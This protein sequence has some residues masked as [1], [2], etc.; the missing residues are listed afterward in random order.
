MESRKLDEPSFE[1]KLLESAPRIIDHILNKEFES[2]D[3]H[4]MTPLDALNK[5]A[6][7]KEKLKLVSPREKAAL[8]VD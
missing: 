7:I 4:T 1:K 6:E 5:L 2:L 3:I 8:D